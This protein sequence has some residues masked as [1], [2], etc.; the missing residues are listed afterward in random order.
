MG[1]PLTT[2]CG[3][4]VPLAVMQSPGAS[5]APAQHDLSRMVW[6]PAIGKDDSDLECKG[7]PAGAA[8]VSGASLAVATAGSIKDG[9]RSVEKEKSATPSSYSGV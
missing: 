6:D 4:G 5:L 2:A 9:A 8:L 3:P 7:A 1:A